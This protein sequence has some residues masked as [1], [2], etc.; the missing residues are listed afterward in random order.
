MFPFRF[1][2]GQCDLSIKLVQSRTMLKV[3]ILNEMRDLF[4]SLFGWIYCV[5]PTHAG[6]AAESTVECGHRKM[7]SHFAF[8][9]SHYSKELLPLSLSP[10]LSALY[11]LPVRDWRWFGLRARHKRVCRAIRFIFVFIPN[12]RFFFSLFRHFACFPIALRGVDTEVAR[13]IF[14]H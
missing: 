1:N 4:R 7:F 2:F 13:T 6:S 5:C 12:L 9:I 8:R 10:Y 11:S 3:N 14:L